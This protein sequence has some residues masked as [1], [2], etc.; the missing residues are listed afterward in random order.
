MFSREKYN[1]S[2]LLQQWEI[3]VLEGFSDCLQEVFFVELHK[4]GGLP[5]AKSS[6]TGDPWPTALAYAIDLPE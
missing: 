4:S 5:F 1:R 6:K 2:P 3:S